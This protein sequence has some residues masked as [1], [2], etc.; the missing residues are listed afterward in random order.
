MI[1]ATLT[2]QIDE[3][4]ATLTTHGVAEDRELFAARLTLR[5]AHLAPSHQTDAMTALAAVIESG[6]TKIHTSQIATA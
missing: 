6:P 3:R 5:Y 4:G 2:I 1:D